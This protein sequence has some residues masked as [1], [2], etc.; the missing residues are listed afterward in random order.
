MAW[1]LV[2]GCMCAAQPVK[3]ASR[4]PAGAIVAQPAVES[5]DLGMYARI[6]DEGINRSQVMEYAGALADGIGPRLTGSPA[7]KKA[8]AWTRDTLAGMGASNA[9]LEDWGEFGI[10]WEQQASGLRMVAPVPA[11][12]IAQAAPWS[13]GT[14]GLDGKPD[15]VQGEAVA[16]TID[17]ATLDAQT[18]KYKGTL[19]GK[20]VLLGQTRRWASWTPR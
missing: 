7:M 16:M 4:P 18:A 2:A 11:V 12:C 15:P 14:V 13:P 9:H 3:K 5:L 6:R 10:G 1:A 17:P 19:R 20:I 8:N